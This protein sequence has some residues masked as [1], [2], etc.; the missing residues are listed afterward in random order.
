MKK[1]I[2]AVSVVASAA[3]L[4]GCGGDADEDTGPTQ[5]SIGQ[6]VELNCGGD[7]CPATIALEKVEVGSTC[8]DLGVPTLEGFEADKD[9][10]IAA[11]DS[12]V[13]T[14]AEHD[15]PYTALMQW[16]AVTSDGVSHPLDESFQCAWDGSVGQEIGF[17][18]VAAGQKKEWKQA[19]IIPTDAV[20]IQIV[21]GE[22]GDVFE[23]PIAD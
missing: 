12:I 8:E 13:S 5:L 18:T 1:S 23:Y 2:L 14:S 17:T 15:G 6:E 20:K 9:G 22:T 4:V 19:F 21:D 7:G 10:D 11:V 3:V 16:N